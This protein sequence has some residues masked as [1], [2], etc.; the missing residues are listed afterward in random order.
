M[1]FKKL[2]I[3]ATT[4]VLGL[5]ACNSSRNSKD[6]G[7]DS[8]DDESNASESGEG[9]ESESDSDSE[10]D[11]GVDVEP[12]FVKGTSNGFPTEVI[13][14]YQEHYDH[15][16]VFYPFL[17]DQ[18]WTYEAYITEDNFAHLYISIPD[19]G[20]PQVDA[21]DYQ[22]VLYL[23]SLSIDSY[24]W[25]YEEQGYV[26][27]DYNYWDESFQYYTKNGVF[28]IHFYGPKVRQQTFDTFPKDYVDKYFSM[29]GAASSIPSPVSKNIWNASIYKIK[30]KYAFKAWTIDEG[31]PG[32]GYKSKNA[33]EDSYKKLLINDKWNVDDSD[34]ENNG[35]YANK[36]KAEIN[37]WSWDGYFF[38]W[39]NR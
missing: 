39:I 20:T 24:G 18:T 27:Y 10:E 37:F 14:A 13:E 21:Y 9:N 26:V 4:F 2:L 5:G 23:T 17:E 30:N 19:S 22:Y 12:Y 29:T 33:I 32:V 38:L 25:D 31:A 1:K 6:S 11:P 34:Y 7:S 36:G 3:L 28:Y 16:R 15:S 35:Y 8:F